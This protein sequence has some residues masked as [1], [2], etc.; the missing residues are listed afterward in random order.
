MASIWKTSTLIHLECPECGGKFDA[1]RLQTFCHPCRSPLLAR[2]DL[3]AV[4]QHL[5]PTQF[6]ARSRGLWRW[7]ELL[8]L[9]DPAFKTTLGEGD[10]PV[11][12]VP[13]LGKYLGLSQLLVKD[14]SRNPTGTFKARGLAVAVSRAIELGVQT[15]VIPTAGNAGGALATY[16]ARAGCI[17][18]VFMPQQAPRSNQ[19][20][21]QLAGA[22]LH[23][24]NG[25]ISQASVEA[26]AAAA[27]F[28]RNET[29]GSYPRWFD[30]STFKEPYRLEGKKTMGLEIAEAFGWNLPDVIIYPTGGGTGLV[31]I[32]K[33]FEELQGIGWINNRR[34]RMVAVQAEACAPIVRAFQNKSRRVQAHHDAPTI[35]FGLRVPEPF[36]DRNI[37]DAL[38]TS[39]GYAISVS[40]EQIKKSS[41]KLAQLEGILA[42]PE[43]AATLA[44]L[45]LLKD[46][47]WIG[48]EDK[49]LLINTGSGLKNIV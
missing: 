27:A 22:N 23:L 24:V 45:I 1:N 3:E 16:A 20:E 15:F 49:V 18:H 6:K 25:S 12:P 30:I 44:A 5:S 48:V 32:W 36:A 11:I 31:G 19:T 29:N 26:Q 47:G 2:Y 38:Y 39:Q 37:L 46:Q 43:G 40:D 9:K 21:V 7:A 41:Q 13:R 35:A 8:P 4:R 14:E 28:E 10:T 33:A 34:P 42:A 17:A